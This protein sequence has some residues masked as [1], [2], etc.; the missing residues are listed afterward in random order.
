MVARGWTPCL[1][2]IVSGLATSAAMAQRVDVRDARLE[3]R[4]NGV[5]ALMSY[6]VVPD[7]ASSALS[8]KDVS[9]SNPSVYMTQFAGGFNIS[10]DTP[11]YL[12]GGIAYSRYDPT[13]IASNGT[14]QRELPTKWNSVTA[15]G[16][17]GWDFP[18]AWE[19]PIGGNFKF[20]PIFNFSLGRMQTDASLASWYAGRRLD[21]DVDFLSEGHMNAYGLGGSAMLVY[22]RFLP[23]SETE[24]EL[25]YTDIRLRNFESSHGIDGSADASTA[26]LYA[27]YRAP[28]GWQALDRP[29]RYVLEYSHSAYLGDQAVLGFDHLSTVGFGFELDS[30]AY[31]IYVTRTRLVMRH[32]FGSNIQGTSIG[33]ALS[34]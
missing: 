18:L 19:T 10:K 2:L 12:E 23:E 32:M 4:V 15:T 8:I 21:R 20:R 31:D 13:F 16:G 24:I 27:R 26:N 29:L 14:E 30:S 28:T 33:L 6:S 5:L 9:A 3:K 22:N 1:L 25:R 11:L 7:L 34:F 17:V